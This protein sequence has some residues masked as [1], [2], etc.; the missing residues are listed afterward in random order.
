MP[1]VGDHQGKREA[2][3]SQKGPEGLIREVKLA[4]AV[5]AGQLSEDVL[6]WSINEGVD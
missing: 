3:V 1:Q 6:G 5:S 4:G 2:K